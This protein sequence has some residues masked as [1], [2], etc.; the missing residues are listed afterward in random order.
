MKKVYVFLADG[1]EEIEAVN[2][3]D[4]LIRA[5][6]QT[7]MVSVSA[8]LEV[9]GSHG[10]KI[11]ADEV[12]KEGAFEDADCLVLPGG[13]PGTDNLFQCQFLNKLLRVHASKNKLIGAIC[14]APTILGQLGLLIGKCATCY[15]G[16]ENKLE[17]ASHISSEVVIDGSIITSRS[18]GTAIPFALRL[19]ETLLSEEEAE[20]IKRAIVYMEG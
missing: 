10:I 9:K 4:L 14:A 8:N 6:I 7:V 5:G 11:L 12:F 19:I 17:G 13:S 1:F 15:P 16:M 18:A 20:K 2:V 3:I